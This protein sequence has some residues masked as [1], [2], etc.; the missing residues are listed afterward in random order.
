MQFDK[1]AHAAYGASKHSHE[2]AVQ[3]PG[4]SILYGSTRKLHGFH[5]REM[6]WLQA[7]QTARQPQN[8]VA[9]NTQNPAA[10]AAKL[11]LRRSSLKMRESPAD[12]NGRNSE[13]V[14]S[15]FH[16]S[17]ALTRG[18]GGTVFVREFAQKSLEPLCWAPE[19]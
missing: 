11:L 2:F 12:R 17:R 14:L 9:S 5:L 7:G 13:D 16:S 15:V 10:R 18:T 1:P 19:S 3:S 8:R 6:K 4:Y